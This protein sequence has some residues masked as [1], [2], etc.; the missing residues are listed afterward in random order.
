[1]FVRPTLLLFK[2]KRNEVWHR[3]KFETFSITATIQSRPN[4]SLSKYKYKNCE[5]YNREG[6]TIENYRTLKFYCNYC[7]KRGHTEDRCKFKNSTW[8][9]NKSSNQNGQQPLRRSQDNL[10]NI[11]P[12]TNTTDS[13]QTSHGL[14]LT[15][16]V[17]IHTDF[18]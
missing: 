11:V 7:D 17:V 1:M 2:K 15:R 16:P 4:N 3:N 8:I 12:S 14:I 18:L 13:S 10:Q 5:H 6:H 9:S